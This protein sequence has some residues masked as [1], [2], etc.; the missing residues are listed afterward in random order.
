MMDIPFWSMIPAFTEGGKERENLTTLARSCA[1]VGSALITIVTIIAVQ[2]LGAGDERIGFSR[3]A[4]VIAAV[5]VLFE[6]IAV[7]TSGAGAAVRTEDRMRGHA[8]RIA[9][10]K[11]FQNAVRGRMGKRERMDRFSGDGRKGGRRTEI[12]VA[13]ARPQTG[14]PLRFPAPGI[15][16][17]TAG[18]IRVWVDFD[19]NLRS[20]RS[21]VHEQLPHAGVLFRGCPQFDD[22]LDS[23]SGDSHPDQEIPVNGRIDKRADQVERRMDRLDG[24]DF[25]P[26]VGFVGPPDRAELPRRRTVVGKEG[27][28]VLRGRG[29]FR[30]SLVAA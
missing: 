11:R 7:I 29:R 21:P 13:H 24:K 5:F 12:C 30:F 4:L 15:Q 1:G 18:G 3:F 19:V 14:S 9:P 17:E 25:R 28:F 6:T 16:L 8:D 26:D 10:G 20:S 22:W 2:A 27:D 23:V